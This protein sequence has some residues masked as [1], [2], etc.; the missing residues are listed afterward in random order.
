KTTD[1]DKYKDRKRDWLKELDQTLNEEN[2][3]K[4][5][6]IEEKD[7]NTKKDELVQESGSNANKAETR[8][9]VL[10][11]G[12]TTIPT[13]KRVCWVLTVSSQFDVCKWNQLKSSNIC[14]FVCLFVYGLQKAD[15]ITALS[16]TED[17][18]YIIAGEGRGGISV[19]KKQ[20]FASS[21]T[22][23]RDQLKRFQERKRVYNIHACDFYYSL[24][25][26]TWEHDKSYEVT[27]LSI[28]GTYLVSGCKDG[29]ILLWHLDF[30]S[31][32]SSFNPILQRP[33]SLQL[34]ARIKS[35]HFG[36]E[37]LDVSLSKVSFDHRLCAPSALFLLSSG[38][39]SNVRC[40]DVI[41]V[42]RDELSR[43]VEERKQMAKPSTPV[44]EETESENT[45]VDAIVYLQ[46]FA[47]FIDFVTA[48]EVFF[49][50]PKK[51]RN[52]QLFLF[53]LIALH[54]FYANCLTTFIFDLETLL[55]YEG[56][57]QTS[58]E[59][60]FYFSYYRLYGT[61][62]NMPTMHIFF[63]LIFLG[64]SLKT[65]IN[66]KI[67]WIKCNYY[68]KRFITIFV[69]II[70]LFTVW[71]LQWEGG[72]EIKP[73]FFFQ[74]T[75]RDTMRRRDQP[76]NWTSLKLGMQKESLFNLNMSAYTSEKLLKNEIKVS[77]KREKNCEI[78]FV[79]GGGGEKK[80]ANETFDMKMSTKREEMKQWFSKQG[81]KFPE[82]WKP[83]SSASSELWFASSFC[84]ALQSKQQ[85]RNSMDWVIV[86]ETNSNSSNSAKSVDNVT[87]SMELMQ[88]ILLS[89]VLEKWEYLHLV[90][91]D[92]QDGKSAKN[93]RLMFEEMTEFVMDTSYLPLQSK[94]N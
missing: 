85:W 88:R 30:L 5:E 23:Q 34:L 59:K 26:T 67:T 43:R 57:F 27:S 25:G 4:E 41:A 15:S 47:V 8:P 12:R 79:N 80:K 29:T 82:L 18:E 52:T 16:W 75:V 51:K 63:I 73:P 39:D 69:I 60:Y 71:I 49:F 62:K 44:M 11:Y 45:D 40:R 32:L 74:G 54:D 70:C 17:N 50:L 35:A 72:T 38:A 93:L 48:V 64:I 55:N 89:Q 61:K 58:Q 53:K 6:H 31:S 91:Q 78:A 20:Y 90:K 68:G 66:N 83:L 14:L 87:L 13:A 76:F 10:P 56:N 92:R 22:E 28:R 81:Y 24:C 46:H 21:L 42:L 86:Y 1:D 37:V 33:L 2:K 3:T 9:W 36:E 65:R 19:W 94:F 77:A 84:R 7:A